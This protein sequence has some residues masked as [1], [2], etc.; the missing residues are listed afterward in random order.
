ME[1]KFRNIVESSS[2]QIFLL[3]KDY[4]ILYMNKVAAGLSKKSLQ[5][6]IG[7]SI[8]E[9]FPRDAASQFAQNIKSVFDTGKSLSIEEVIPAQSGKLYSSTSL[10]PIKDDRGTVIAVS[11]IVRDMTEHKEIENALEESKKQY[12]DLFNNT[13][14]G[15]AIYGARNNGEDFIFVNINKAGEQSSQVRKEDILGKSVLDVFPGVRELG[16]F[17]A[18]QDVWRTGKSQHHPV[19][20][21][22]D[23]RISQWVENYV[24]KLPSGEIVA[25]Y[26]D[27]TESKHIEESLRNSEE[28]FRKFFEQSKDAIFVADT[29][30][31][32]LI[33]CNLQA[34]KLIGRQKE[35]ILSM[36]ADE[37]H[38]KDAVEEIMAI[39]KRQALGEDVTAES[40]VLTKD[41]KRIPVS[42]ATA[43]VD[44]KGKTSLIGMFRD[45]TKR[46]KTEEETKSTANLLQ[47]II[48]LLPVR[49]F[50]KDK[51]LKFLGCNEVFAKDAG[52]DKPRDLI[53]KDDFH[54]GWKDQAEIYRAD[55]RKV[56]NS[57]KGKLNYEEPQTTP[58]GEKIWLKTSKVPLI[59]LEGNKIGILGIYE[60][61]TKRKHAE[62]ELEKR[63]QEMEVFNKASI[64]REGKIVELKNTIFEL[65]EKIRKLE[66]KAGS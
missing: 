34:E 41:G 17:K 27:I 45:I 15:I 26:N 40:L 62:K 33:D 59:D 19:S 56:I 61:I 42:I 54:M 52:K 6:M 30:T 8:F 39:F 1:E 50:W 9:I 58:Q 49:I 7:M 4:K 25:I 47:R 3:D 11:G 24:Y 57:E 14:S 44:I 38:P 21:Y 51:D 64:N 55:D 37:L 23:E 65:R 43:I 22:K 48:D 53:G 46:K 2:D 36:H 31:R 20:L 63:L 18:F 5:E 16:L 66:S 28:R 60:D 10:N 32:M 12:E 13:N 35:E 29:E